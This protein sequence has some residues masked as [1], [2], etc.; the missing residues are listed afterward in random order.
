MNTR[1]WEWKPNRAGI[2]KFSGLVRTFF[3]LGGNHVQVNS[4]S[5]KTLREAQ[6]NPKAHQDLVIRVAGYSAYFVEL[7]KKM[8]EDI[9]SRTEHRL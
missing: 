8:Q 5:A 6:K 1:K 3:D 9:I 4:I 2:Q 7:D